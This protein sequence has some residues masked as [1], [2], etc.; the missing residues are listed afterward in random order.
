MSCVHRNLDSSQLK[1]SFNSHLTCLGVYS[2]SGY[3]QFREVTLYTASLKNSRSPELKVSELSGRPGPEGEAP[4]LYNLADTTALSPA[5][6]AGLLTGT[7]TAAIWN[8]NRF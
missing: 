4:H 1:P 7:A 6:Y 2:S 3:E 8:H 5:L